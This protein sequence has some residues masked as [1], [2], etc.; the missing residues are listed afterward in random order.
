MTSH[1]DSWL[2]NDCSLTK[3]DTNDTFHYVTGISLFTDDWSMEEQKSVYSAFA[4]A[5]IPVL[6]VF[7]PIADV[8]RV[9]SISSASSSLTCAH[10][11]RINE[12]S[13][14]PV[15]APKPTAVASGG[16]LNGGEIAGV[17][18]GAIAILAIIAGCVW[19]FYRRRKR[20]A[21]P[22]EGARDSEQQPPPP[23]YTADPKFGSREV[24][25]LEQPPVR[26]LDG[27]EGKWPPVSPEE[28]VQ[29]TVELPGVARAPTELPADSR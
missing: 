23:A 28:K 11:N 21:R 26:E 9:N 20:T 24:Q 16:S 18:I 12:G 17:A 14:L 22:V 10:V 7:L 2:Y 4:H 5:V 29:P 8:E 19:F 13:L 6:T 15:E 3:T 1:N 27:Y 25:E